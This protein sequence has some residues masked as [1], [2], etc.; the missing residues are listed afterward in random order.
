[1]EKIEEIISLIDS[2]QQKET[3]KVFKK[4]LKKWPWFIFFCA[5]GM[6]LGFFKY[7]NSPNIYEVKSRILVVE[8]DHHLSSVLSFDNPMMSM[9]KKTNIENKIGILQSYT[10]FRKAIS[11]LNWHTSWYKQELLY[12]KEL[13]DIDPFNLAVPPNAINAK[14][15]PVR[16]DV[17]NEKEYQISAKGQTSQNGYPQEIEISEVVEF[18]IPYNNEFF[19]FTLNKGRGV[20]GETYYLN[21][22]SITSLTNH[23]LRKTNITIEDLNSD[24]IT[25]MIKGPNIQ[26]EADFINELTNV[27]IQFG[28]ENKNI[29]SNNSLDFIDSQLSRIKTKLRSAEENFSNYRQNKKVINLSQEAQIIYKKLEEIENEKYM[30]KLQI[31]Y[32]KDLQQYLDDSE[33]ISEMVNP[34]V[35][36]IT[37]ANLNK[38]L[39]KLMD[40][41]GRREV[42]S[43]SVKEKSPSF[44]ILEKEIKITR[45]ALE[46]TLKNQLKATES[47][48]AS[49]EERYNELEERIKKLPETEKELIGIQREFDLNDELYTYLLQKRAE[50][51]IS[52]ASIAP[53]VQVIDPAIIE[54]SSQIGPSLVKNVGIGMVAGLFIPFI[55]ITLISFFNTKIE[56]R[57]EIEKLLE[58]ANV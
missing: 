47:I 1:M 45:D 9:G 22:N 48:L 34:S 18:E 30:T 29:S 19:N 46:E 36:G 20:A 32:Y 28:V 53:E 4:Y 21:F 15:V 7:K 42:L 43:Y 38:M 11:N 16:I 8:E 31:D 40:L 24:L 17:L 39:S 2:H 33:K 41:Y 26:K 6:V 35:I 10:L 27:F 57:E 56:S 52:K 55:L 50:A 13:Y 14:N 25:I 37:D 5:L 51:S 44:K 54:A 58:T 3:K 23:Y 12:K 49:A